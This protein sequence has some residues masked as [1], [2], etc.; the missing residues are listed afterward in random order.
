DAEALD[1]ALLAIHARAVGIPPGE[2][3]EIPGFRPVPLGTHLE[4]VAE[5]DEELVPHSTRLDLL[6]QLAAS[7][8]PE[9]DAHDEAYLRL[10]ESVA[11]AHQIGPDD[12]LADLQRSAE[13]KTPFAA[14][15]SGQAMP[16]A[17]VAFVGQDVCNIRK[18]T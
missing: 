3:G 1:H 12:L 5:A 18:V 8:F 9:R 6:H 15:P 16:H 7:G 17:A 13:A 11:T 4:T 10:A 14:T 2:L